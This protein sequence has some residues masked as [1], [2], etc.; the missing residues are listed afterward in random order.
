MTPAQ[1]IISWLLQRG[2]RTFYLRSLSWVLT[3]RLHLSRWSCY[4]R[5]ST[6]TVSLRTS[7]VRS[8]TILP[9]RICHLLTKPCLAEHVVK[10]LPQETFDAIEAA[11][12]AHEPM[13]VVN[14]SKG[15]GLKFDIF[16]ESI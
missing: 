15:W 11:A 7:E 13:R 10:K 6:R 16:D 1:V 8:F 14:P 9:Y 2:V 3:S 12:T 4:P 5:V